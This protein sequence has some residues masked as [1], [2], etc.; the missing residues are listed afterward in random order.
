M[1]VEIVA[2][3]IAQSQQPSHPHPGTRG[4][5]IALSLSYFQDPIYF[6]GTP[7]RTPLLSHTFSSHPQRED[8]IPEGLFPSDVQL[9]ESGDLQV[10]SRSSQLLSLVLGAN[11]QVDTRGRLLQMHQLKVPSPASTSVVEVDSTTIV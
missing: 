9:T 8:S 6:V 2:R 4:E 3:V 10:P 5:S 11:H 7:L 1:L